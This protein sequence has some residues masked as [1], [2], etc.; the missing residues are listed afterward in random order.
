MVNLRLVRSEEF[1]F[2]AI[3]VHFRGG[4]WNL[5]HAQDL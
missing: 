5:L 2:V 3:V 1:L 4:Y